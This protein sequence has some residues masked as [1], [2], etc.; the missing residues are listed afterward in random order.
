MYC[1]IETLLLVVKYSTVAHFL[2]HQMV[3]DRYSNIHTVPLLVSIGLVGK[4]GMMEN[5]AERADMDIP[6]C[7]TA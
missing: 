7:L 2:H 4:E 3:C 5:Q 6:K 1:S